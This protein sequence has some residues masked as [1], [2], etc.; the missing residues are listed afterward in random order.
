MG[1]TRGRPAGPPGLPLRARS[2]APPYPH[3]LAPLTQE[4]LFMRDSV[5]MGAATALP[6]RELQVE[7][8]QTTTAKML[9]RNTGQVVDQYTIDVVGACADVDA[10]RAE[11]RQP[12]A[13]RRR[14]G[15]DHLRA[16][17][18]PAR[19][20]PASSR[21]GCASSPARTRPA[22]RSPRA[23]SRSPRSTTS[24]SNWSPARPGAAAGA[25]TRSRSTTTATSP[26]RSRSPRRT[27]KRPSTSSSTT[28]W[29]ASSRAPPRSSRCTPSRRSASSRAPTG[30]TRSSSRSPRAPP[31]RSPPA[32]R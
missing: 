19:R 28:G 31:R 27:R 3:G 12:P 24:R 26:P 22:R 7:P 16:G 20:R 13:R 25:G 15:H 11:G 5:P 18:R 6:V 1:S 30:S 29:R 2:A 23:P 14:R 32:A 21:S 4:P 8:G 10:G 9:V 17:P